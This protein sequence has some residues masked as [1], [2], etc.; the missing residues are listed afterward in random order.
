MLDSRSLFFSSMDILSLFTLCLYIP[1]FLNKN[2]KYLPSG[3]P[4]FLHV[5][6]NE[7]NTATDSA[8]LIDANPLAV[9]CLR[10]AKSRIDLSASELLN[11][12]LPSSIILEHFSHWLRAY[13]TALINLDVYNS[14]G[15]L[16]SNSF[17]ELR[18]LTSLTSRRSADPSPN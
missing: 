7:E 2:S 11:G 13:L 5:S 6:W 12:I 10:T 18:D 8:P 16:Y 9:A 15:F 1:I 4:N 3:T 14:E 17:G